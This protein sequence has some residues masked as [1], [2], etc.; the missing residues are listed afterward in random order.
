MVFSQDVVVNFC[1]FL[2]RHCGGFLPQYKGF[3][4]FGK[5]LCCVG[6]LHQ[7]KGFTGFGKGLRGRLSVVYLFSE[8]RAFG[9]GGRG[10]GW[11]F[12]RTNGSKSFPPGGVL[13]WRRPFSLSIL[14]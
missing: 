12:N 4:G 7:H 13:P 8:Y 2:S 11:S 3:A 9:E 10:R 5:G 6:F 14:A 1:R